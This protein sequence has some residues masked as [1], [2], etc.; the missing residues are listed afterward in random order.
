MP[1]LDVPFQLSPVFKPKIWG[2]KDLAP[3]FDPPGRP[4][5][6]NSP[7]PGFTYS[8]SGGQQLIGEAW[9]TDDA[10]KFLNGPLAGL[11]LGEASRTHGPE[12]HGSC[13]KDHRFPILAKYIFTTDWLSVQVHPND[14]YA[15][16]NDPGN[17]GKCEMW[18][19]VHADRGAEILLG[20]KPGVN[21][22]GLRA[23]VG[24]GSSKDLLNR[25]HPKAGE[26]IFVP[27]GTVHA[28]GP[29]LV[30][31]EAEENSDLTYRLDDF[32]RVGLDG[33]PR[34]LHWD[35]GLDVIQAELPA[36]RDLPRL[37]F[38]EPYGLRRYVLACRFFAVE[39]LTL[40]K[41]ASFNGQLER[42]EVL[43]VL[44][45][46]GR[47]ETAAGWLA[48]RPG[49]TWLIPPAAGQYRLAP[50]Q[51]TRLLRIY[52]PDVDKDFR[53]PLAKRGVRAAKINRVVFD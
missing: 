37:E 18:Y 11:T 20:L 7:A 40:H 50:R 16:A 19:V 13:W 15:R 46:D 52:V 49:N 43:S 9:I 47:V 44:A 6:Q 42:V 22:Q 29:G 48:Y 41:V 23:A 3:L 27:P 39:E 24:K 2:R 31:F 12:L 38:R 17:Q 8:G 45:G 25:F 35:K 30:L 10:A 32:G 28:L 33:N 1:K 36:N 26:A 4:V 14:E 21:K 51:E 5:I 34:P 53:C